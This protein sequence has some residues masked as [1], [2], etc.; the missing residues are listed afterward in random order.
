MTEE[1][2]PA[3][4]RVGASARSMPRVA[5]PVIGSESTRDFRATARRRREAEEKLQQHLKEAH[6]AKD[7]YA[8]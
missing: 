3:D 8:G 4:S 7:R 6:E 1:N 2:V 5:A